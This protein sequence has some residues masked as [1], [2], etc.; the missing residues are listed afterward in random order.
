MPAGEALLEP[1]LRDDVRRSRSGTGGDVRLDA[2]RRATSTRRDRRRGRAD[3]ARGRRSRRPTCAATCSPRSPRPRPSASRRAGASSSRCRPGA[4]SGSTLPDGVTLIDDCY[5]ANP[6][7][8]RA[9]LDDLA[10][11]AE[12][13]DAPR[14]VAVLGDM[15][16]L[17]PDGARA[18]TSRSASTP[19]T[20]GVDLL[21]T[22][23]PLAAAMA[24]GF[25]GEVHSVADAGEAAALVPE[26]LEPGDVV[27][28]KA[29]RGVGLELVC[30][31]ARAQGASGL[32]RLDLRADPDRRHG[33][34]AD[35]P[36]PEPE[37]HRVPAPQREFG[38]NIR[39]EGPEGHQ[40]KAG[41]PTMGG[42]IIF[43]AF[44][45]PFLILSH[46]RLAVDRACSGRRSPARCSGSPTTTRRSSSAARSG[47]ARGRSWSSRS[48]SRSGCGGSR[49][50]RPTSS[51]TVKLRFVDVSVDLGPLYPVFIYLVVA[52]HDQRRQPHRRARRARRRLRG[53]RAA[54]VHRD[55]VHHHRRARPDDARG[56]PRSARASAFCGS[57]ASRRA[58]SWA[59]PARSGSAA[60]SPGWR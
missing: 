5:N 20:T 17:G 60:R 40:A 54:R 35:V 7:S 18:T 34:A 12:R 45:V 59:T 19:P 44:A 31:G 6:M 32:M 50:R 3:R 46:A 37:V 57:T 28:V 25:D 15:L 11:T 10:A 9:A 53:D 43:V 27:L 56:L 39:E 13:S 47:C 8:M 55:H 30:R 48:R 42:I 23:G 16:E 29:S 2:R 41:T 4:A 51:P 58:S 22:V 52:G 33:V 14:R 24:D 49:R 21:V 1:H 38:Q 26:L 36:V